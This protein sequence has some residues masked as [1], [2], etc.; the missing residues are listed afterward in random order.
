MDESKTS[1]R[2][3]IGVHGM[4]LQ[5]ARLPRHRVC[6]CVAHGL[7]CTVLCDCN[8]CVNTLLDEEEDEINGH[9]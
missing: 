4:W 3:F 1:T 5:E 9:A 7:K 8:T 6:A 2:F